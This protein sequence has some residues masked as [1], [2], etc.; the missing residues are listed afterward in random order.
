[1]QINSLPHVDSLSNGIYAI[2]T[3]FHRPR[4]AA[5]YLVVEGGHAAYVDT[6]TN[7]SVPRLLDTLGAVGL[8][9]EAV[10]Y[11]IVTHV[12]LDHAGGAGLLLR[13]LP[14]AQL[15][16]HPRGARHMIDPS[17]L[18]AGATAVYGEAQVLRAY[19]DLVPVTSER[20]LITEDG[21]T[22]KLGDRP[23]LFIDTPGHARHH[24][25]LWDEDSQGFFTGDTFGLSFRDFDVAGRPWVLPTTSPVQFDPEALKTS[26]N[27]VMSFAPEHLY[28]THYGRVSDVARL[29][30]LMQQQIDK[31]VA[32]VAR[33]SEH[34][35]LV[36][37]LRSLYLSG[38][39]DHG[40]QLNDAQITELLATDIE[41]NAQGLRIW[42]DQPT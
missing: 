40:C 20:L 6:G 38:A 25:C 15:V 11:V 24:H 30:A 21:M 18:I 23:L 10:S 41:L 17:K 16:V 8:A 12:H 28:L 31:M 37:A 36:D 14:K 2:D 13:S 39:R 22:L 19:G 4:F 33:T 26:V 27:R 3:G 9:P 1:M 5:A 34:N 42:A 7:H 35:A 29:G 32:L